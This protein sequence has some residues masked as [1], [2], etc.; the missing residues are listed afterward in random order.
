[1]YRVQVCE[2]FLRSEV[3]MNNR[4][5]R[6]LRVEGMTCEGCARHVTEA[7]NPVPGVSYGGIK[8]NGTFTHRLLPYYHEFE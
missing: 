7:L 6:L 3:A 5:R 1:M 2:R 8:P 4:R